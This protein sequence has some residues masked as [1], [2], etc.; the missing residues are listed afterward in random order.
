MRADKVI[1][2]RHAAKVVKFKFRRLI[3]NEISG[4][5]RFPNFKGARIL[6]FCLNVMGFTVSPESYFQDTKALHKAVLSWTN[7]NY[8]WLYSYN[9]RVGEACLPDDITFDMENLKLVKTYPAE[10]LRR[11]PLV[12]TFDVNPL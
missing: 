5:K 2:V 1:D 11:E 6:R 12:K 8:A 7:K 10:G 4:M 3:Y 9:P